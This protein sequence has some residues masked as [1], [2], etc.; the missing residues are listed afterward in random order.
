MIGILLPVYILLLQSPDTSSSPSS[1]HAQSVAQILNLASAA[2]AAFRD[3]T[4]K[5]EQKQREIL[6]AAVRKA[7][8]ASSASTGQKSGADAAGSKPKIELRSF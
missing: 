2:P 7:M 5:L 8:G 6:E 1:I 4:G 3:A